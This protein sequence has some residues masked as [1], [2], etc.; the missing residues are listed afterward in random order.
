MPWL[1][2]DGQV[3]A[4]LEVAGSRAQRRRGLLGRDSVEG[5]FLLDPARWVHT[6]GMRFDIDVAFLDREGLVVAI[7][8]MKRH[9]VGAPRLRARS[10]VETRAGAFDKWGVAVGDEL[11]I[12]DSS[13]P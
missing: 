9:R 3:I 10:V 2:R 5:G 11:S 13:Q 6:M 1:V 4:S 8:T 12:S 7:T